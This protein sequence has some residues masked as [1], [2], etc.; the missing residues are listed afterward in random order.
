MCSC[1]AKPETTLHYHLRCDLHSAYRLELRKAEE[2]EKFTSR[3]N[4]EILKCKMSFF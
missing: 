1:G 3:M 2:T 4:E